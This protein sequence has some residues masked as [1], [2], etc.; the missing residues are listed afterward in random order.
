M[1]ALPGCLERHCLDAWGPAQ[2]ENEVRSNLKKKIP[3]DFSPSFRSRATSALWGGSHLELGEEGLCLP[4][5]LGWLSKAGYKLHLP[6]T[7]NLEGLEFPS[8]LCQ[9]SSYPLQALTLEV[10]WDLSP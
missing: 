7:R 3:S 6:M 5:A 1:T 8:L 9:H 10:K 2:K 4:K